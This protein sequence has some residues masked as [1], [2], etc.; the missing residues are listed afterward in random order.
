V[1]PQAISIK[2]H[3][4]TFLPFYSTKRGGIPQDK[5]KSFP[6]FFLILQFKIN[7]LEKQNKKVF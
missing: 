4:N 1:N 2:P 5:T 6:F 3:P 7:S